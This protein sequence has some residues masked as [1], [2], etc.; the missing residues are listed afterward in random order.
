MIQIDPYSP[1][2]NAA[3]RTILET[4]KGSSRKMIRTGSPKK[5][6]FVQLLPLTSIYLMVKYQKLSWKYKPLISVIFVNSL[7]IN[8]WCFMTAL[9]NNRQIILFWDVIWNLPETWYP[10]LLPKSWKWMVKLSLDLLY[11]PLRLK[12][13]KILL[14][15]N[16]G[17]NLL[18]GMK[19]C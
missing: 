14:I 18:K 15:L 6:W 10:Q 1:W 19:L 7:G 17:A 5:P 13:E 11:V 8:G 9:Y 4:K 16:S 2:S 3:E 12:K